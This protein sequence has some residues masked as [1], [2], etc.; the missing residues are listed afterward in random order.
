MDILIYD[1]SVGWSV[2]HD[3]LNV[4][5]VTLLAPIGAFVYIKLGPYSLSLL[6]A[7]SS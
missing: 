7:L 2:C 3:F 6:F 4:W 1:R 5:E